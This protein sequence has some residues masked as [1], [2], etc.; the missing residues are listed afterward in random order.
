MLTVHIAG[1]EAMCKKALEAA[2]NVTGVKRV[3]ENG[4]YTLERP[5]ILGVT[6]L[7][8]LDDSDLRAQGLGIGYEDLVMRNT[9][10]AREWGLDGVI[11]TVNMVGKLE[12][13]FGSDFIYLLPG[14]EW[15]GMRGEE[16]KHPYS[17]R[18]GMRACKNPLL[19]GGSAITKAKSEKAAVYGILKDMAKEL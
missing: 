8:S 17:P 6:V 16:Q 11:C 2:E 4:F 1:G 3:G 18:E 13:I 19:V 12:N 14:M 15:E 5:K 7:S 9:E 10:L